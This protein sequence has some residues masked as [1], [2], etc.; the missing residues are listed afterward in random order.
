MPHQ[1]NLRTVGSAIRLDIF[2]SPRAFASVPALLGNLE[3]VVLVT[4]QLVNQLS[5][6]VDGNDPTTAVE[7]EQ[8]SIEIVSH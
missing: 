3:V 2:R 6:V 4:P 5:P 8:E 7:G 1:A